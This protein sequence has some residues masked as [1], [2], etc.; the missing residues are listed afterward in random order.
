VPISVVY[1]NT[2][3]IAEAQRIGRVLVET[4]LAASVNVIDGISS[5]YRWD[6]AVRQRGEAL[7]IIK[8]RTDLVGTVIARVRE[9]HSYACPGILALPVIDGNP[10]YLEW[11]EEETKGA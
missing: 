3:E 10:D 9:L 1:V 2:G 11:V 7:L 8:T 6:G 5:V 4:G